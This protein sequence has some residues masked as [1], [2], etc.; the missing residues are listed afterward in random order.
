MDASQSKFAIKLL[1]SMAD[2]AFLM[3]IVFLFGKMDGAKALLADCDAGWHIRTGEWI[4]ANHRV[5]VRDLF[6]FSKP[7]GTWYAWEWLS[8]VIWAWLTAHGGL[9]ALVLFCAVLIAT[10]FALLF[11]LAG[12][13]ASRLVALAVVLIAASPSS[14]HWLARP[15]LFTLLFT[16]LFYMA[17]ERVRDG[18]SR[19]C[20]VPLLSVLPAVTILWTNLHG[21]FV[22]GLVLIGAYAAGESLRAVFALSAEERLEAWG[23]ARRYLLCCLGCLAASLVNPYSY[24]LHEHIFQYLRDPF[25]SQYITEF[26]SMSFH[27]PAALYFEILLVAGVAAACWNL[28]RRRFIEPVLIVLW[29]HVALLAGRNIPLF[30]IVVAP[31]AAAALDAWIGR[32]PA[33]NAAKWL[34]AAAGKFAGVAADLDRTDSIGRWHLAS[35]LGVAVLAALLFA[36]HPPA[37][38]RSE[39]DPKSFPSGAIAAL[40]ADS[41]ARIFSHDQWGDYLIY[42]LFPRM[43]VF[44]DGRSDFYGADFEKKVLDVENIQR[45]WQ[46][47]LDRFGIDTVLLSVDEPLAGALRES[48]RWRLVHDDGVA[49][50]FRQAGRASGPVSPANAPAATGVAAGPAAPAR[51]VGGI[52]RGREITKTEAS[53]RT[54]TQH[55]SAT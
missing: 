34:R 42:R 15:H 46:D 48:S 36:P 10:I 11:R 12:R 28:S 23:A 3:P 40:S 24:H 14:I 27:H 22:A 38:F 19:V 39:F 32:L 55:S 35:G 50:I 26:L 29:A 45:G 31:P 52:S 7:G 6:S 20:G 25:Q 49:L 18:R 5:P 16:V 1:P 54:I 8:D 9:A 47:T 41:S 2:L 33:A 30:A 53:D 21:G 4:L 17:L 13:K 37:K 43:R 51:G 44:V